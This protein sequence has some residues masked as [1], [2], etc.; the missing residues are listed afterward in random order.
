[1][2]RDTS[3]PELPNGGMKSQLQNVRDTINEEDD[4]YY[5]DA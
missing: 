4:E 2:V 1:L 3:L 5:Q